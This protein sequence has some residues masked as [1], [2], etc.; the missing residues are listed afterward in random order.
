MISI[1]WKQIYCW[2]FS[3]VGRIVHAKRKMLFFVESLVKRLLFYWFIRNQHGLD[4]GHLPNFIF[5]QPQMLSSYYVFEH[6]EFAIA[7]LHMK[8]IIIVRCTFDL[9]IEIQATNVIVIS[10][11]S[12]NTDLYF[13][14]TELLTVKLQVKSI[15]SRIVKLKR[16]VSFAG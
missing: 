1:K 11:R 13:N 3:T 16:R 6:N 4:S 14:C 10:F 15:D 8:K 7:I 12:W 9:W 5:N 2:F